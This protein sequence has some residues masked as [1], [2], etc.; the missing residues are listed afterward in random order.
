MIILRALLAR[1]MRRP[2][3]PATPAPLHIDDLILAFG[4][5]GL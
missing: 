3:R 2:A 4:G 1:F 5:E